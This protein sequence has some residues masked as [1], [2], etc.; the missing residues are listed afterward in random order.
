MVV[1]RYECIECSVFLFGGTAA[2]L[3][4][5]LN[6]HNRRLHVTES[7][8]WTPAGIM[9]STHYSGPDKPN[10]EEQLVPKTRPEYT[11]PYGTTQGRLN[12]EDR[13]FLADMLVRW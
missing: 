7:D 6:N 11:A 1:H 8:M 13:K 12:D 4:T 5:T 2:E 10:T 9:W 3:A